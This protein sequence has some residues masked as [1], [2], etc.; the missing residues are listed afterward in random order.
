M[1]K[2]FQSL[3]LLLVFIISTTP[4]SGM[5]ILKQ[6]KKNI[7]KNMP[8]LRSKKLKDTINPEQDEEQV[9]ETVVVVINGVSTVVSAVATGIAITAADTASRVV[10]GRSLRERAQSAMHDALPSEPISPRPA[11][12]ESRTTDEYVY[13]NETTSNNQSQVAPSII[14]S[15]TNVVAGGVFNVATQIV[16][17]KSPAQHQRERQR[18]SAKH[19]AKHLKNT[20]ND[21]GNVDEEWDDAYR[22][23]SRIKYKDGSPDFYL[24]VDA[25]DLV[26]KTT[27][28]AP[29]GVRTNIFVPPVHD[30]P[31]K[32]EGCFDEK[33]E[34]V[35]SLV[36]DP[37]ATDDSLSSEGC[38]SGEMV[39]TWLFDVKKKRSSTDEKVIPPVK[40]RATP[41]DGKMEVPPAQLGFKHWDNKSI[42]KKFFSNARKSTRYGY[43]DKKGNWWMPTPYDGTRH[44]GGHWDILDKDGKVLG[45]I[46]RDGRITGKEAIRIYSREIEKYNSKMK[47]LENSGVK[48]FVS[49]VVSNV[50]PTRDEAAHAFS[51]A[52]SDAVS[53]NILK[54]IESIPD[55]TDEVRMLEAR[56][57]L[58]SYAERLEELKH[59]G[60]TSIYP[61]E[62]KEV[63]K[64][65]LAIAEDS[66]R[67]GAII[68]EA[69]KKR[70]SDYAFNQVAGII[71]GAAVDVFVGAP[72]SK[73]F[74]SRHG[75]E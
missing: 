6:E 46:Y 65:I 25:A 48:G 31:N 70:R 74:G 11:V 51:V 26:D 1:K 56:E 32:D 41:D 18:K 53:H 17:G 8:S 66:K 52:I 63:D 39:D 47:S 7:I 62:V 60:A 14:N 22:V 68:E 20:E 38:G 24:V 19:E 29:D 49:D 23:G 35:N 12:S 45:N 57:K 69:E 5:L 44:S 71:I 33:P 21:W 9:F 40:E 50:V 42:E 54:R 61:E 75:E 4:L 58:R 10:T 15:A 36:F 43:R 13:R 34:E 30:N 37:P 73:F 64:E 28:V 67:L 55:N 59:I 3:S 2:V 72:I 27:S 16:T